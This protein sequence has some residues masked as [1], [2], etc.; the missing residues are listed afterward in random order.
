MLG[1]LLTGPI[2]WRGLLSIVLGL[3]VVMLVAVLAVIRE[4]HLKEHRDTLRAERR[5]S[6]SALR[7]LRSRTFLG[8]TAVFGFAFAVM[9]AYISAS[10]F[11][12]QDMIGF[13]TVGYGLAFGLNALAL[14]GVSILSAKL[15]ATRSVTGG[16]VAR[17][18]AGARVDRRVRAARRLRGAGHLA[19]RA[20]VHRGGLARPG[21]RQRHGARPRCGSVGRRQRLGRARCAA[22]RARG[23]RVPARQHRR[24]GHRGTVGD[25]DARRRGGGRRGAARGAGPDQHGPLTQPGVSLAAAAG[26]A[27][28]A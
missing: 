21:A 28:A 23:A 9:M 13:G 26:T 15:T 6:G 24:L 2:G 22:V 17:H 8:Y 27:P 10:P 18:R 11:L 3:S 5:G 4:T 25:R 19:R 1:G 20:A 7:A 16:A 12:Y 14:M